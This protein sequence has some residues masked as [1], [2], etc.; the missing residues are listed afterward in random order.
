[1][2]YTTRTGDHAADAHVNYKCPCGCD[3]G[4]VYDRDEGPQHLGM[5]CFGPRRRRRH[6]DEDEA[7]AA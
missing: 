7:E 5:C 6:R 4:L 1:M 3:A 2:Q